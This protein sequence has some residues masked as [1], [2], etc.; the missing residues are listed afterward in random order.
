[1]GDRYVKSDENKKIL[2]MDARNLYG[3]SVSQLL[4]FE[5]TKFE[6]VICLEEILITAYDNEIGSFIEVDLKYPENIKEKTKIFPFCLENKII[7]ID[8]YNHYMKKIKPKNYTKSKKLIC[9]WTDK[10]RYLILY[11][12]L[13]FYVRHGMIVEK[14]HEIISFKQ[15][16]TLEKYISFNTQKRNRAKN[17]FEKDFSK[18]LVNAAFGNFLEKVRNRLELELSK[19]DDTKKTTIKI[20]IQW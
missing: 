6:K 4:P 9:D 15:S 12:M 18:L 1:M 13:K 14:I 2:Y 7:P 8:K 16:R 3:H 20:N 17:D 19:K 10:K 5:E 11:S